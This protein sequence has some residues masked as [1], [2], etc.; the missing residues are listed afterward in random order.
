M[1]WRWLK[2]LGV[3]MRPHQWLKNLLLFAGV[4]FTANWRNPM[5]LGAALGGFV[6]FSLLSSAGYLINDLR[7]READRQHPTKRLRPIASGELPIPIAQKAAGGLVGIGLLLA[8]FLSWRPGAMGFLW[9]TL[10][11]LGLN[12]LYSLAFK[13]WV[14]ADVLV[15][16]SLFV[17]RAIA[18]CVVVPVEVSPWLIV[19]TFFG[20]LFMALCKRRHEL[21]LMNNGVG[22]TRPVLTHYTAEMLDQLITVSSACAIMAYSLYTFTA[23]A[24][25]QERGRLMFTIPFV[26]YGIFRYLYLAHRRDIGGTPELMFRD[27][28][29]LLNLLIW[30][31]LVIWITSGRHF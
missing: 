2:A 3:S 28:P 17:L 26:V 10:G 27:K 14:M 30:A 16:A 15:L 11:Y 8:L 18:G 22:S 1:S 25:L 21:V 5:A 31:A 6:V 13:H 29:M 20:A 7:D 12:L 9:T 19:C 4:V 24:T 23:P